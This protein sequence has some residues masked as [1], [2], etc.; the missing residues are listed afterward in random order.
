MD[1][2]EFAFVIKVKEIEVYQRDSKRT[3]EYN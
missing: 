3:Q 2:S 1:D